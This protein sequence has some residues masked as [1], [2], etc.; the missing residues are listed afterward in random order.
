VLV[1]QLLPSTT[2]KIYLD[3]ITASNYEYGDQF[4]DN[5]NASENV[6]D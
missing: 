4:K 5:K 3:E 1:W 2:K 6:G